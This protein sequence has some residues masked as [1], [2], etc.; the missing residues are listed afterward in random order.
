[1]ADLQPHQPQ[2][3]HEGRLRMT[4]RKPI[5]DL[6]IPCMWSEGVHT[7]VNIWAC[8]QPLVRSIQRQEIPVCV[9][10]IGVAWGVHTPVRHAVWPL[11][12]HWNSGGN[13]RYRRGVPDVHSQPLFEQ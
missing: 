7:K 11:D 13:S 9:H 1:M 12:C 2:P 8:L 4:V 5:N 6:L 10:G 3:G